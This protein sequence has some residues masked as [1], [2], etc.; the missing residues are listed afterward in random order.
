MWQFPSALACQAAS[1][2]CTTSPVRWTAKSMIVVVPPIAAAFVPVSKVSLAAVPP[3][4][5]S[6]WVCASTPP[7][8][9]YLPV[10]SMVRSAVK[11]PAAGVPDAARAAMRPSSIR[12]SAWISSDAV[13]TR[14]P[15]M[16]VR[17]LMVPLL[18]ECPA[19]VRSDSAGRSWLVAQFPAPLSGARQ[20]A[21]LLRSR[22]RA[23]RPRGAVAVELPA[24]ADLAQL[25]QVQVAD[26]QF[27]LLVARHLADE[28]RLR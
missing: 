17:L 27:G 11:A 2:S 12:T 24:V 15:R 8:I 7:G 21:S 9:T 19:G 28:L 6:M 23:V 10:A 13:M 4:G 26:D 16:T 14:P 22:Q 25:R 1:P 20:T 5:S 3:N 18:R